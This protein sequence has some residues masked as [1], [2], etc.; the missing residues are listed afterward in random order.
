MS[1]DV[2]QSLHALL[3]A[4][5]RVLIVEDEFYLADDI[6][7]TLM[8]AGASINGPFSTVGEAQTAIEH[9]DFDCAVLDINVQGKSAAL[10]ATQLRAKG[11]PFVLATGYGRSAVPGELD[12]VPRIEK[13]FDPAALVKMLAQ[14]GCGPAVRSR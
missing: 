5:K 9:G 13:P 4:G 6:R 12:E 10:L 3:L 8:A 1:S 11:K 2:G 7:R 14:L